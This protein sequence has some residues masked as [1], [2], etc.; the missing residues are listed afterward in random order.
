VEE[1]AVLEFALHANPRDARAHYFL[2]NLLY[3]RRR[4]S[5]AISHW[6]KAAALDPIFAIV[7]RNLGIAY[8]NVARNPEKAYAAYQRAFRADMKCARVLFERDQL[9]KRLG[10]AP[11]TRLRELEKHLDLVRQRDDLSLELCS[12]Y[13]QI[14]SH[15]KVL[16]LL[17]SRRFQPW[18]GGEGGPLRQHVRSHLAL[19]IQALAAD[20]AN[21]AREHFDHALLAPPNL[22]EASHLL[23]NK[24]DIYYW[25]G[26]AWLKLAQ[27]AKASECWKHAAEF[28]GDFQEMSVRTFSELTFYSALSMRKLDRLAESRK[29]LRE[30][31]AYAR[32]LRHR[33]RIFPT[34]PPHCLRC[35]CLRM[36]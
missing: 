11:T 21:S 20:A 29:L 23:A 1:I 35:C 14:G 33:R 10:K 36:T 30:L 19:G 18:E 2:G 26:E 24:S 5:E 27:P 8:F 28:K 7:W 22:G 31:L 25:L 13:N 16:E 4:H 6:E 3:D 32:R 17:G 12:L 15:A 34:S 9:W